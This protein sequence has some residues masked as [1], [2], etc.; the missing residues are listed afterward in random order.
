MKL[1]G[2]IIAVLMMVAIISPSYAVD[3]DSCTDLCSDYLCDMCNGEPDYS[4]C[5][6]NSCCPS[7]PPRPNNFLRI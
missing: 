2:T 5:C 3:G 1:Q 7:F 6:I 4:D